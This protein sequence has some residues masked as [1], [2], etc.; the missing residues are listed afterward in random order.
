VVELKL[1]MEIKLTTWHENSR[2]IERGP[3]VYA[4]RIG[5]KWEK[6]TNTKDSE[7]YGEYWWEVRPTTPWNFG[8][9]E[10]QLKSVADSFRI[11]QKQLHGYPWNPENSPV[12]IQTKGILFP[13]WQLYN[14]MA[15]P[16]PWSEMYK[17]ELG[18][19]PQ[20]EE[21]TLIP[22]GCTTLRI[23]EFPVIRGK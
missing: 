1:P 7:R 3:L 5:E 15:G 23:T 8:I 22:Y 6:V 17:P 12:E 4:L 19:N 2:V 20:L 18:E 11:V 21:I 16:L 13:A 10:N 9:P 14:E